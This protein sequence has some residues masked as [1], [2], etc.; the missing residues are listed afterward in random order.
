MLSF[1]TGKDWDK[2]K[3]MRQWLVDTYIDLGWPPES[4]LRCL[5]GDTALFSRLAHRAARSR[6]GMDFLQRLP[7]ALQRAPE[8]ASRWRRPIEEVLDDPHRPIDFE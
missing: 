4:F 7:S 8:L 5:D 3:P 1:F 6:E 2:A